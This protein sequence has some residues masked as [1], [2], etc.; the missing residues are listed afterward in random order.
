M[1]T[2]QEKLLYAAAFKARIQQHSIAKEIEVLSVK[3]S[4]L[5][6][7]VGANAAATVNDTIAS[8]VTIEQG[9]AARAFEVFKSS[10][11]SLSIKA[12]NKIA[13]ILTAIQT[14]EIAQTP[15]DIAMPASLSQI[16]RPGQARLDN[17]AEFKWG[18]SDLTYKLAELTIAHL[19][20]DE[21]L[22]RHTKLTDIFPNTSAVC[23]HVP[24]GEEAYS[25]LPAD[26]RS[27]KFVSQDATGQQ[28]YSM[29]HTG[30]LWAGHRDQPYKDF[31]PHDASSFVKD[32]LF[33]N[34]EE[35]SRLAHSTR[36]LY[37]AY[38]C[39]DG[40]EGLVHD[41]KAAWKGS[42]D[43]ALLPTFYTKVELDDV[44]PGDIRLVMLG[45][46]KEEPLKTPTPGGSVGIVVEKLAAST[47]ILECNRDMPGLEGTGIGE[48]PDEQPGRFV[49]YLRFNDD[50]ANAIL[51]Q[52]QESAV[53]AENA[54]VS[55]LFEHINEDLGHNIVESAVTAADQYIAISGNISDMDD[56]AL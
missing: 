21:M 14:R 30:F 12:N 11:T 42:M 55:D 44:R 32:V 4:E 8:I 48:V 19:A 6:T 37:F 50:I 33:G 13:D 23:Q 41:A 27:S 39:L 20:L 53:E 22:G 35:Y 16:A 7:Q 54:W 51:T 49:C 38:L 43:G 9:Y 56:L 5:H 36:D 47:K 2:P 29:L 10:N 26:L 52:R 34:S 45:V 25:L 1:T 31:G 46:S 15:V 24:M 3:V 40:K 17:E 18:T 28:T